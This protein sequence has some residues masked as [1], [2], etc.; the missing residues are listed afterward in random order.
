MTKAKE[1]IEMINEIN[2]MGYDSLRQLTDI[3]LKAWNQTMDKQ[4][5]T[6]TRLVNSG[7][8]QIKLVS[9]AKDYQEVVRGQMDLTRRIGEAMVGDTRDAV[10]LGQQT[11]EEIRSWFEGNFSSI[12][13]Q[14]SKAV[15]KAA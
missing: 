3:T 11:G 13:E 7:L 5:E 9:E 1:S 2:S 4:V 10:E 8:E 14:V 15:E 12:N 6:Y